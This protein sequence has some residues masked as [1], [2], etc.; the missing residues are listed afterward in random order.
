MCFDRQ[1]CIFTWYRAVV[2]VIAVLAALTPL[3]AQEH[4]KGAEVAQNGPETT[5]YFIG[6]GDVLS[7]SVLGVKELNQHTRVSNSGKIHLPY[8]GIIRVVDMTTAQLE[9]EISRL[10]RERGLVNEAWVKVSVEEYRAQ[11]VYVLGEVM[12]PGQFVIKD[13]M[14]LVDLIT[15]AGGFNDVATPVGYLYRRKPNAGSLPEGEAVADEAIPID[16]QALNEGRNPELNL[17]LRGGDVLYVP[18]RRTDFF[19]VVGDVLAP[20][21]F[22]IRPDAAAILLSQAL[23]RAGGPL[24]TAKMSDAVVVRFGQN[25]ERKEMRVDFKAILMGQQPD[26]PVQPNDIIFVPGSTAKTLAYGMLG[27]VPSV[28]QQTVTR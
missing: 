10:L 5:N 6:A 12:L 3:S 25:G 14:Y 9:A 11:P 8:L 17:K 7:I 21:F 20:G 15:L 18:Q 27:I 23:S 4:A 26:I 13:E 2:C 19:Y 24:R 16:F 28:V 1:S 22:E